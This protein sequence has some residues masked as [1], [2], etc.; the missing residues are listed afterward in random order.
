MIKNKSDANQELKDLRNENARLKDALDEKILEIKEYEDQI[1]SQGRSFATLNNYSLDLA[2]KT[3]EEI[4]TFISHQFKSIFRVK[5]VWIS[6]YDE[7]EKVL[8]LRGTTLSENDNTAIVKKLGRSILGF[9]TPI[10]PEIYKTLIDSGVGEQCSLFDISFGNIPNLLSETLERLFG[11]GWFQG[12][13]LMDKGQLYGAL[14][15]AGFKGQHALVKEELKTFTEITSNILRRRQVESSLLKSESK[16]REFSDLLPQLIFETDMEGKITFINEFGLNL[17]GYP[18]EKLQ[19]QADIFSFIDPSSKQAIFEGFQNTIS[20]SEP[21]PKEYLAVRKD[22]K[23]MPILMHAVLYYEN[24]EPR[25]IR[26]TGVDVTELREAQEM[27]SLE[28]TLLRSLIDNLPDRIYA[29]DASSRFIICN[30]ALVKRMG[31]DSAD[32]IIGKSDMELLDSERAMIYLDD[33][34]NIIKTGIPLVNKEETVL[35]KNGQLRYSLS[36]KIPLRN[37]RGEIVGIVGI[38]RDITERKLLEIEAAN[39]NEQLQKIIADRD[40]FFSIIAHDLKSP[41]NY[42]L[43]FTEL[44]SDQIDSMPQEKIREIASNM[45]KSAVNLYSLLENLLEWS[46]MQRGLIDFKPQEFNLLGKTRECVDL[47][48][49]PANKKNIIISLN[50]SENLFVTADNHMFDAIIRNLV[51]N[52]IKFSNH[53]GK[54]VVSGKAL[55]NSVVEISVSDNGIGMDNEIVGNLF[56]RNDKSRRKG[57]DAEP[58]TGLGLLLCKEFVEKHGGKI[59]VT[60]ETGK[61]SIFAFTL[62]SLIKV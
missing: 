36:T 3:E 46:K 57:T 56:I 38:G 27:L 9:K 12:V 7:K 45:R 34:Q 16:F 25:G 6:I 39:K 24:D 14:V 10:T 58:S 18:G 43:G 53:G 5:E 13:T 59:R 15:V 40:K 26:G 11:I 17:L 35:Y 48:N 8:I 1:L 61:G 20:G 4:Y 60:S 31:R 2:T 30:E 37:S 21:I 19:T 29:K 33:E 28:R 52:A 42:F 32:E 23:T 55:N 51:S 62:N 47:I 22:G 41:F 44:I 49:G 54:I 50:V